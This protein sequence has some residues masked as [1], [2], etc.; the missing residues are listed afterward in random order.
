MGPSLFHQKRTDFA[1]DIDPAFDQK[2]FAGML[3]VRISRSN[4]EQ[5]SHPLHRI[6]TT[7]PRTM[8]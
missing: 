5:P 2:I 8:T 7:R 3:K 6:G 1:E 4:I